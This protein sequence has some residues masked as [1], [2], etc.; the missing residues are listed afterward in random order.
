MAVSRSMGCCIL[1]HLQP[2]GYDIDK[3]ARQKLFRF[4]MLLFNDFISFQANISEKIDISDVGTP[5]PDQV[6]MQRPCL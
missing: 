5:Q 1:T 2:E 4:Y 6:L 3:H